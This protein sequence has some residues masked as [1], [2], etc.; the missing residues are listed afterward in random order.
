MLEW[1]R[2]MTEKTQTKTSQFTLSYALAGITLVIAVFYIGFIIGNIQGA[3]SIVPIG[4][5]R[6]THQGDIS[7]IASD[8]IDFRQF[9]E[10]WNL[11]KDSYVDQP[12]SEKDLFYGA[13]QGLLGGLKDPYSVYFT[14]ELAQEFNQELEGKFF[15][16]GA[17]I[18]MKEES[19][20]V[21]APL[22]D[23]PAEKA[24]IQSGDRILAID[25]KDTYGISVNEAVMLIRGEEGTPVVL[26]VTRDGLKTPKEIT[27]TRQEITIKSV[28]LEIRDD[29]IAVVT[30]SM[31][32]DDTTTLFQQ[33]VQEILTNNVK[34]IV[35]DLRNDPGG[36]LTEAVNVAGFWIDGKPVVIEKVQDKQTALSASGSAQLAGIPT[37]VLVNG[38]SASASEILAGALQDYNLATIIGEQTFGK[39][40]V[41]EFYGFP[42]SSAV[43]V[44]VAEWLTPN[45]RSINK[46]GIE[47]DIIVEYTQEDYHDGLT[48]Q[49][50][51]AI[52]F[53]AP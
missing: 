5:G 10:V 22:S 28:E 11:V 3:R 52:D 13:L 47:P 27:I 19:L 6:V 21:I 4:E 12:V 34:G 48:P 25:G 51:A 35:L 39:G 45:G 41:Q 31:F 42:D 29:G 26:A 38:G 15:G 1:L 37:V 7:N 44:T 32:N 17:E 49:L 8:D 33:A 14:P 20:V 2:I 9:W 40:S 16:I 50:D 46:T 23:S 18:G 36:L 30:L 24:G 53:L 43:K